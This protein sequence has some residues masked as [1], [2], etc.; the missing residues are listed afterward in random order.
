MLKAYK[1]RIYPNK[2]QVKKLEQTFGCCRFV[3]NQYVEMFNNGEKLKSITEL[4]KEFVFLNDVS[5]RALQQV[6]RNVR[7]TLTQFFDKERKVKLGRPNFKNKRSKQ[8]FSISAQGYRMYDRHINIY[9]V[10]KVKIV[11]DREIDERAKY[12]SATITKTKTN[13]YY[14]S[15]HVDEPMGKNYIRTNKSIGIDLGIS[16]FAT[17]SDGQVLD[18]PRFISDNQAKIKRL[19]RFLAKKKKGSVRYRKLK[20][21]IAK[22]YESITNKR[23]LFIHE[24]TTWL[25]RNYDLICIEDLDVESMKQSKFSK[26]LVN[27]CFAEFR[28]QLTYKCQ[29]KQKILVPVNRWFKSSK[30]CSC[31][32]NVKQTL[33]IS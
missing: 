3:W 26:S 28:R 10:G 23:N 21:R 31:C 22:I 1:F 24:F 7:K 17:L 11:Y 27:V 4:K 8:S 5:A 20:L 19:Q 15:I 32:G 25:V 9:R 16:H 13:K 12:F 6:E 33:S 30:K 14:V 2:T 18:S 29:W